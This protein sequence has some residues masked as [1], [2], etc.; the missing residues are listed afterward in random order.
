MPGRAEEA[1]A[2]GG[3]DADDEDDDDLTPL[4]RRRGRATAGDGA[5][6]AL[7]LTRDG[8]AALRLKKVRRAKRGVRSELSVSGGEWS[9]HGLAAVPELL[10]CAL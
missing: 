8:R 5:A 2:Q 6:I 10:R 9:K 3:A 7:T 1:Q 4:E